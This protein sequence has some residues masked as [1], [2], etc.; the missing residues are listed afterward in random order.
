MD[1][2]TFLGHSGKRTFSRRGLFR[3]SLAGLGAAAFLGNAAASPFEPTGRGD[4][5]DATTAEETFKYPLVAGTGGFNNTFGAFNNGWC[6]VACGSNLFSTI[7]CLDIQSGNP[8]PHAPYWFTKDANGRTLP[9]LGTMVGVNGFAVAPGSDGKFWVV[10]VN[11]DALAKQALAPVAIAPASAASPLTMYGDSIVYLSTDGHLN[12]IT[13]SAPHGNNVTFSQV[14]RVPLNMGRPAEDASVV[15]SGSRAVVGWG[16]YL[17]ILDI[18]GQTPQ[19]VSPPRETG[20]RILSLDADDSMAYVAHLDG[21]SAFSL[22]PEKPASP[23]KY[24]ASNPGLPR[25]FNAIVYLADETGK[26]IAVDGMTGNRIWS[27]ELAGGAGNKSPIFIEDGVAY[28]TTSSTVNA[29]DLVNRTNLTY[30][31]G[32]VEFLGV[33]NGIAFVVAGDS[34]DASLVGVDLGLQVHGFAS[35]SKLLAD[36]VASSTNAQPASPV[37]RSVVQLVDHNKNPRAFISVKLWASDKVTIDAEGSVITLSGSGN[38]VAGTSFLWLTTDASGSIYFASQAIDIS[39]PAIY[40]WAS[41]MDTEEAIVLYPDQDATNDLAT[42]S[43]A[44]FQTKAT[45]D[46]SPLLADGVDPGT[47]AKSLAGIMA[48]NGADAVST[49]RNT[50]ARVRQQVT[51]RAEQLQLAAS[52]PS[53]RRRMFVV[54]DENSYLAYPDSTTNLLYQQFAG[55]TDRSFDAV[56]VQPFQLTFDPNSGTL[57]FETGTFVVP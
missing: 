20:A 38:G 6:V 26:F 11:N 53:R 46:G 8:D 54:Q 10:N 27:L 34:R 36:S 32:T 7:Q 16:S 1:N 39:S 24:R 55:P 19:I 42:A 56:N 18:S 3:A 5:D 29:I 43:A 22:D 50:R 12:A 49:L 47:A 45:F 15:I 57:N 33:E 30:N 51:Q 4:I 52:S 25:C 14:W 13:I 2:D 31:G 9:A 48:G 28:V 35:E 41:F 23:W 21:V 44:A 37:F 17:V 40:L